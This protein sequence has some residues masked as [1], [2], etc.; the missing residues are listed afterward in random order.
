[1]K[2][3]LS[4]KL[5]LG[6][7]AE[8]A[9]GPVG[10]NAAAQTDATMRAKILSYSRSRGVF[11]GLALT[12]AT[13]RQDKDENKELYGKALTNRQIVSSRVTPPKEAVDLLKLLNIYSSRGGA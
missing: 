3:V 2:G 11:G 1:M 4:S 9:A 6:G 8:V 7:G 10:R 12:G 5:T 13:L